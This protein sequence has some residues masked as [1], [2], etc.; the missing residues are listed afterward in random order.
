VSFRCATC[1]AFLVDLVEFEPVV[2]KKEDKAAAGK[3]P[4]PV[5]PVLDSKANSR[6][7]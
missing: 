4:Q 2:R 5:F 7:S 3:E 6:A 1:R